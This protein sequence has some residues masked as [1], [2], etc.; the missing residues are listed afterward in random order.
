MLPLLS[1]L[2]WAKDGQVLVRVEDAQHHAVG[3]IEIGIDG[4]GG[5]GR[6]GDDGKVQL[7]VGG[8][9][10]PGDSI[11]LVVSKSPPPNHYLIISPWD[12]RAMVPSFEDKPD[13]VIRVVVVQRGERAALEDG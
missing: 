12:S 5:S 9:T 2:L 7:A 13:N 8:G 11:T 4:I 1:V 6:T 3:G 10:R